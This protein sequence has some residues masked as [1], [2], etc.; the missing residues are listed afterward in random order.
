[1]K[2]DGR[3]CARSRGPVTRVADALHGRYC[4]F[5]ARKGDVLIWHRRLVHRGS[6]AAVPGM[7]RPALVCDYYPCDVDTVPPARPRRP[8]HAASPTA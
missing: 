3:R 4:A 5:H 2:R 1:M 7:R 6:V 8:T